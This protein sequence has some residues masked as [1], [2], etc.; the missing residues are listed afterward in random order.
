MLG[1]VRR[2][3]FA[4]LPFIGYHIGDYLAHWLEMAQKTEASKLPRIY[5]VNWFRK[6]AQNRFLWPGF[7]ENIRVLKWIFE[8]LDGMAQ[9][10]KTPIGYMPTRHDIDRSGLKIKNADLDALLTVDPMEWQ[11]ELKSINQFYASIGKKLPDAL[12]AVLTQI[13]TAFEDITGHQG[14]D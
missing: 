3:P 5:Y 2:D 13:Q 1:I 10:K 11:D 7:G 4:M 6:D 12:T 14:E 8:R 9:A